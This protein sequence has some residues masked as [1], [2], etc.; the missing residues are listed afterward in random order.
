M[1]E[2]FRTRRTETPTDSVTCVCFEFSNGKVRLTL[3]MTFM[4]QLFD[5]PIESNLCV[6]TPNLSWWRREVAGGGTAGGGTA[7]TDGGGVFQ[8]QQSPAIPPPE[9][10]GDSFAR[11]AV[12]SPWSESQ[13]MEKGEAASASKTMKKIRPN[14]RISC[15]CPCS[16]CCLRRR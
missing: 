16:C 4:C 1:R 11:A 3:K 7:M 5:K 2:S 6:P 14:V 12:A 9:R 8:Q 15:P 10:D 13:C